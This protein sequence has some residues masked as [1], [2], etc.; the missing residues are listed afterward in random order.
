MAAQPAH[1]VDPLGAR[2]DV[3]RRDVIEKADRMVARVN[4]L[5]CADRRVLGGIAVPPVDG[6]ASTAANKLAEAIRLV[7]MPRGLVRREPGSAQKPLRNPVFTFT[8]VDHE[9]A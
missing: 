5:Q 6:V 8:P 2:A 7:P 9:E 3:A 1:A 4:F